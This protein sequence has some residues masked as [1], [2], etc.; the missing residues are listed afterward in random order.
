MRVRSK[1]FGGLLMG[2]LAAALS[3]AGAGAA[4]AAQA[5]TTPI[6][7]FIGAFHPA[8]AVAAASHSGLSVDR[9]VSRMSAVAPAI[10]PAVVTPAIPM[11]L[12]P[13]LSSGCLSTTLPIDCTI[14][15]PWVNISSFTYTKI[16]FLPGEHVTVLAGGCVQDGGSG[17]TWHRYVDP[18][19]DNDL[20]HG[21]ITIPGATGD[22]DRLVN[23]VGR[24]LLVGGR[25]GNL[26]LGYQDDG[27]ADNGYYAH[28][29]GSGNQCLNSV[30]A[31]VHIIITN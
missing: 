20:Y 9:N 1:I 28:D 16:S 3:V 17:L 23:V 24:P 18:A 4:N 31:F 27:Y 26:I 12:P 19:A 6:T 21:L 22:Q 14:T 10:V 2:A 29:N 5:S 8:P 11:E 15:E 25:G 13:Q 7:P 30:N